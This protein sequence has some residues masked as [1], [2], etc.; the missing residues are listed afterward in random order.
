[1]SRGVISCAV[2]LCALPA[3]GAMTVLP[4]AVAD[5]LTQIDTPPQKSTLNEMFATPDA[6]LENLRLIALDP[7]V[8]FGAQLRAIRALPTYCPAAPQPCS[9]TIHTTLVALIDAYERSPHSPLDVLRLRAAV[10]ALGVTRAGTSSDVAELSPL[11]GDPSRDVR[12]T[13]AQ[14]LRNLCNAEA[15]EP[16]RARLQIE[17][18][19]QV[20]AA[21][22]A[23][24]RDLRQCP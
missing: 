4:P 7:M 19:E 24:L 20:R 16:L 18:V 17:Q 6:A 14:A 11:L 1:M 22:T 21:L 13:V 10:E 23:A 3:Q 8:E 9:A 5:A 2:L 12:A 15:I